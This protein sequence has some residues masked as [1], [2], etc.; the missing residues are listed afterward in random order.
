MGPV[1]RSAVLRLLADRHHL[2]FCLG[3]GQRPG[4]LDEVLR[5]DPGPLVKAIAEWPEM[6]V[7]RLVWR[8]AIALGGKEDLVPEAEIAR[9]SR[10]FAADL[11][12]STP[13][14]ST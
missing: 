4:E 2:A 12:T 1:D 3:I 10:R 14:R 7:W 11:S 5:R 13:T 8:L 9:T 6:E